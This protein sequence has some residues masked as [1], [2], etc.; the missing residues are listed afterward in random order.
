VKF[1]VLIYDRQA[2]HIL[3][4][5]EL[6]EDQAAEAS[7]FRFEAERRRI[8]GHLDQEVVLFQT[9]SLDTLR[10]THGSYFLNEG[11]LI[12]RFEDSVRPAAG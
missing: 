9:D 6:S 5:C 8:R 2:Q 7:A 4:L 11:E 1:F 10:K 3:E 12:E